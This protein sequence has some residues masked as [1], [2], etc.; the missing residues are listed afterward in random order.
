MAQEF[1]NLDIWLCRFP[2][3]KAAD[4]YFKERHSGTRPISQFAADM[5]ERFYDHDFMERGDFFDPP[6]HQ[7]AAVI[8]EHSFSSSYLSEVVEAFRTN[9]SEPFNMVLLVWNREIERPVSVSGKEL[10]L[11]YLGR[12]RCNPKASSAASQG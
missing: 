3:A 6:T 2:S 9:P 10:S 12:F 11:H 7:V 4:A 1:E 5:G 8:A